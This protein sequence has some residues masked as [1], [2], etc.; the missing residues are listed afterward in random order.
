VNK[1]GSVKPLSAYDNNVGRLMNELRKVPQ[2][3]AS[4]YRLIGGQTASSSST[5]RCRVY[6]HAGDGSK[7]QYLVVLPNRSEPAADVDAFVI[8]DNG[9]AAVASPASV[10]FRRHAFG[11]EDVNA[12]VETVSKAACYSV[13]RAVAA[14]PSPSAAAGRSFLC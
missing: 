2:W 13:W 10:V 11:S 8:V 1:S 4:L 12:L 3:F 5:V 9:A 6:H 7:Q 14:V